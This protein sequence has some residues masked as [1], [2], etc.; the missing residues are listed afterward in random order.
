[1]RVCTPTKVSYSDNNAAIL[2]D[3]VSA[4]CLNTQGKDPSLR[5]RNMPTKIT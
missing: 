4:C 1:M 3:T 5:N 2:W